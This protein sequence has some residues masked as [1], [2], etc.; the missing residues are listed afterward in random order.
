MDFVTKIKAATSVIPSV[1]RIMLK[2]VKIPFL[3]EL[4]HVRVIRRIK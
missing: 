2:I 4:C 1:F 3:K